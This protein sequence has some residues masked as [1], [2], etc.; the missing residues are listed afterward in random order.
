VT[1]GAPLRTLALDVGNTSVAAALFAGPAAAGAP[2]ATGH[3]V[4]GASEEAEL[5]HWLRTARELA[6]DRAVVGSVHRFGAVLADALRARLGAPVR[7][8]DRGDEFPLRAEVEEPARVGVDRLAAALAAFTLAGGPARVVTAGTAITVDWVGEGPRFLGGA[9]VPGRSLQA[10]ALHLHTDRLP[11]IPPW[12]D[13][14]LL[15]LPGRSSEEAIRHGLDVGIP[16]MV[17]A[18]LADLA[19]AAAAALPVFVGGGDADWLAGRLEG[20]ARCE[21]FLAARGLALAAEQAS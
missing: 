18:L 13:R 17:S 3:R 8:L 5:D 15:R 7:L 1:G 10:R 19:R 12:G 9:I 21:R 16:G 4:R 14:P 11:A 6:P 20:P 2:A